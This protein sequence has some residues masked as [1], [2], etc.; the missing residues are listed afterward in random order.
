MTFSVDLRLITPLALDARFEIRGFT[1]LLGRSGAG[2]TS[3][4]RALAGLLPATGTPWAG[5]A[6]EARPV[7]YLPQG[8]ALF[9][10]LSALGNAAYALRG[11]GRIAAAQAL[12]DELGIGA[13]AHRLATSLSGGEAQRVALARALARRPELLLLDEPSAALDATSRDDIMLWLIATIAAR[14]IP[15]LAATHDPAIAALA[16][17]LVLLAGGRVI[18]QGTPRALIENPGTAAAAQL[19]GY[20]NIWRSAGATYAIRAA[21]IET[22]ETG[23]P[24]TI[25][26]TRHHGRDLR[27]H[28]LAPQ[29]M[30]VLLRDADESN[31]PLGSTIFL[32]FP[33]HRLRILPEGNQ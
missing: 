14:A 9:P 7:G 11:A 10:H 21:D 3:L 31:F 2:K 29:P 20:E 23:H 30:T 12:L 6:P 13:L 33:K 19:L 25:L 8:A 32:R 17:W 4:L 28:C 27:L 26:T 5:L 16:D 18:A 1:A 22:A 15:A 24:A